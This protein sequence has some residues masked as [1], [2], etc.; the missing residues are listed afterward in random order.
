VE[1]GNELADLMHDYGQRWGITATDT[2]WQAVP[3]PLARDTLKADTLAELR[4]KIDE[5]EAH[6]V[7]F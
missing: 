7:V 3:R 4:D 1:V 6:R 5:R 2:G